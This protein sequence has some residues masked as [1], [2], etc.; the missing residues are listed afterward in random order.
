M[1][2]TGRSAKL[3]DPQ[4]QKW[5]VLRAKTERFFEFKVDWP[6]RV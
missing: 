3:D 2:Q 1:H 6:E 5:A 4:I